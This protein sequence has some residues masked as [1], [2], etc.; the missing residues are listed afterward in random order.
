MNVYTNCSKADVPPIICLEDGCPPNGEVTCSQLVEEVARSAGPDAGTDMCRVLAASLFQTPP[1]VLDLD[2]SVAHL[3]PHA[4]RLC[5]LP[6]AS[7]VPDR[8]PSYTATLAQVAAAAVALS[9]TH[10]ASLPAAITQPVIQSIAAV[11]AS[12]SEHTAA[13]QP[14]AAATQLAASR[15]T[16]TAETPTLPPLSLVDP[17]LSLSL[18]DE[19][20]TLAAR[21]T[22]LC[23]RLAPAGS[24][25]CSV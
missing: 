10:T 18:T 21:M 3:C 24:R 12:N 4:C 20:T 9:T 6:E 11:I 2:D 19:S 23:K 16:A 25:Q 8:L 15:H 5:N 14:A 22:S 1:A 7:A 13:A 17:L